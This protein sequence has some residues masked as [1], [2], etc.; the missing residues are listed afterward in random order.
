MIFQ[1]DQ[2]D[3]RGSPIH[4]RGPVQQLSHG[5]WVYPLDMRP[6][7]VDID[8][9]ATSLSKQCRYIGHT[10]EFYSVAQHSVLVASIL[11]PELQLWGLLHDAAEAYIGD[12]A[13]PVKQ[14]MEAIAPGA[15]VE[16]ELNIERAI[17]EKFSLEWPM[18]K[19]VK[20]ADIVLLATEKRDLLYPSD[21]DWGPLPDPLP[22]R[23]VP[24][25]LEA[26]HSLFHATFT[27]LWNRRWPE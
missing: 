2:I 4:D 23:I 14:A 7:D 1:N 9:I 12:T 3:S 8:V 22:E 18:P 5:K 19:A 26:A 17:A 13:K 27:T 6:S 15:Y 11:P 25:R 20:D 10:R 24:A 16:M 21:L